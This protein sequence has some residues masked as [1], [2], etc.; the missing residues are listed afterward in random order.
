VL[1]GLGM[2]AGL[3]PAL[4]GASV[5]TS[6]ELSH[7][8]VSVSARVARGVAE[9]AV[10]AP[11]TV[12]RSAVGL[13]AD[14]P[15]RRLWAV[16]GR[17]QIEVWG[18]DCPG[19]EAVTRGVQDALTAL[20]GV[21]W[22][23]VDVVTR[24]VVVRFDPA[25]LEVADL[26]EAVAAAEDAAGITMRGYGHSAE[27]FPGDAEPVVMQA[28]A[29]AADLVGLSAAVTGL[30]DAAAIVAR[31]HRDG[32]GAG[33]QPAAAAPRIGASDGPGVHRSCGDGVERGGSWV[34]P[35]W[36]AW[37]TSSPRTT[38]C[39]GSASNPARWATPRGRSCSAGSP[40]PWPCTSKDGRWRRPAGSNATGPPADRRL[41]GN[42][43]QAFVHALMF[44]SAAR[45]AHPWQDPTSHA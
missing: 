29:L 10:A 41:R 13:L 17:A 4:V 40:W 28:W 2:V 30:G 36:L 33:G 6:W 25:D 12:V 15:T 45:L 26:V 27:S 21:D 16:D 32:G 22:A 34:W 20:Q 5:R 19:S 24:R 37:K 38:S 35:P 23:R 39:T 43:P 31:K 18:L 11:A 3:G 44:E 8:S 42:L 14:A 9:A 1:R 7:V